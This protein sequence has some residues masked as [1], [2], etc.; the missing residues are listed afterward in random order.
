M[1]SRTVLAVIAVTLGVTAVTAQQD[2]I[3]AR[4]ALMKANGEQAA[5]GSKMSKGEEPFDLAK[6]KK[7]LATFQDAA[8]AKATA[9]GRMNARRLFHA[10]LPRESADRSS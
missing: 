6:A 1:I 2:P 4:K 5:I 9:T 3:A 10:P 7:V 8:V